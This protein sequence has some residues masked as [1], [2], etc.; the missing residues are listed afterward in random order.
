MRMFMKVSLAAAFALGRRRPKLTARHQMRATVT[1]RHPS[2]MAIRRPPPI[3]NTRRCS[4]LMWS[5]RD[6]LTRADHTG[7]VTR[8]GPSVC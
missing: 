8:G 6:P 3:T 2:P 7:E 1:R 5:C 4:R